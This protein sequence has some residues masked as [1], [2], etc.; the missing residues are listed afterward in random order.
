M[1]FPPS[2]LHPSNPSYTTVGSWYF[3]FAGEC[4]SQVIERTSQADIPTHD[5][6]IALD[7]TI[8]EFP[9]PEITKDFFP[10]QK[11]PSAVMIVS[12][13]LHTKEASKF[14][15]F[16]LDSISGELLLFVVSFGLNVEC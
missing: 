14:S 10:D 3:R 12:T 16:M 1:S 15:V 5:T 9:I 13:L 2:F 6:I 11:K 7:R 4:V 8:R